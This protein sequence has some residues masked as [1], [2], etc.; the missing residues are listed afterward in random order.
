MSKIEKLVEDLSGLTV[1]EA[2][3]LAKLL[4]EKWGVSAAA[5]AAAAS[6]A[7]AR[8]RRRPRLARTQGPPP[9][10]PATGRRRHWKPVAAA[11]STL[12][13]LFLLGGGGWLASRQLFFVGTN[14]QGVVTIYRGLPY[15]LPAGIKLYESYYVSGVPV[16]A[17]PADRRSQLL[18]HH[19][20]SQSDASNLVKALELG[21]VSR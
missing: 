7:E 18:N 14:S 13:V 6:A 15:D 4:E 9:S 10:A 1:L 21:Q 19:L 8:R 12:I 11:V 16:S 20:R 3:D 5:P 17:V 2:A